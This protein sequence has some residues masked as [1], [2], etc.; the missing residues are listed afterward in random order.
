MK[1]S[2]EID[3]LIEHW[4]LLPDEIKLLGYK[5]GAT[6][7]GFAIILKYFQ[8]FFHFPVQKPDIPNIIVTHIASQ[9]NVSPQDYQKYD[10][11]SRMA[12]YHRIQIR[13]FLGFRKA[14][15]SDARALVKWLLEKVLATEVNLEHL[16]EIVKEQFLE[17]KIEPP[18]TS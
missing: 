3:E 12:M 18:I 15:V 9:V 17:L 13:E 14:T 1:R 8:L 4:T 7:L 6:R 11:Q 2:W 16:K 10:W 5:T